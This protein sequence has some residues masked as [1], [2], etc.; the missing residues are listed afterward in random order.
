MLQQGG[1]IYGGVADDSIRIAEG[2]VAHGDGVEEYQCALKRI[3]DH[4]A[5]GIP[6]ASQCSPTLAEKT[7]K[8]SLTTIH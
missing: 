8:P 1:R 6:A 2:L 4:A 7:S 5:P 3:R